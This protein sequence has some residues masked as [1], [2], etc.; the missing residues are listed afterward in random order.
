[1]DHV[2]NRIRERAYALWE[3]DGRAMGRDAYYWDLAERELR[4]AAP[5]APA[6]TPRAKAAPK[7]PGKAPSKAAS[8]VKAAPRRRRAAGESTVAP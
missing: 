7:V 5:A 6:R 8:A 2:E 3:R 1:M 4:E